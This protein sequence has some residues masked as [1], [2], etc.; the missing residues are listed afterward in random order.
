M[1]ADAGAVPGAAA[2]AL[3]AGVAGVTGMACDPAGGGAPFPGAG[4]DAAVAAAAAAA[5]AVSRA[6]RA[7]RCA[8]AAAAPDPAASGLVSGDGAPPPD[9]PVFVSMPPAVRSGQGGLA[10]R[11]RPAERSAAGRW[12]RC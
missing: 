7:L 1:T 4:A 10:L 5:G 3:V 6:P 12:A 8:R 11:G 9:V 2:A